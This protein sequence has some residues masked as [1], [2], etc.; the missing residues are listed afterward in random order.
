MAEPAQEFVFTKEDEEDDR[1]P[2]KAY[3]IQRECQKINK[4]NDLY[5]DNLS[6][7]LENI[8]NNLEK[9]NEMYAELMDM[10]EHAVLTQEFKH[11]CERS[12]SINT[13]RD[14]S[15]KTIDIENRKRL[16]EIMNAFNKIIQKKEETLSSYFTTTKLMEDVQED[17]FEII[18][19][20]IK[21][22]IKNK[23]TKRVKREKIGK[24][25][26]RYNN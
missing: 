6:I 4:K 7:Q 11:I 15:L 13:S 9:L 14:K 3:H 17:S 2:S 12:E 16:K 23:R 21:K 26:S 8:S 25:K 22:N 5:F 19:G 10:N 1:H 24:R 20:R 18:G